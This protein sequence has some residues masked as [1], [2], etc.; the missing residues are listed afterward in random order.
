M[1][2]H[3]LIQNVQYSFPETLSSLLAFGDTYDH[4]TNF[5]GWGAF[6]TADDFAQLSG[7][8]QAFMRG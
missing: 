6:G 2:E 8:Q 1:A 3:E 5:L 4:G 7:N